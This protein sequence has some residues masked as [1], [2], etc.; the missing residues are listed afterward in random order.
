MILIIP[1]WLRQL[2]HY[3]CGKKITV[4]TSELFKNSR[5]VKG[6][7]SQT[8]LGC[9]FKTFTFTC[10]LAETVAHHPYSKTL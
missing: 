7:E 9:T 2:L 4:L 5:F 6:N 3:S 1:K 8:V 10:T